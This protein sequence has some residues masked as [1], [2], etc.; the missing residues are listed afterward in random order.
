MV[1]GI[2]GVPTE[3]PFSAQ[4]I[5][6]QK[7]MVV[8]SISH[9]WISMCWMLDFRVFLAFVWKIN[10][11]RPR[12]TCTR[13]LVIVSMV[14][15]FIPHHLEPLA[16]H[17]PF[18]MKKQ[19]IFLLPLSSPTHHF[20]YNN[21]CFLGTLK[22]SEINIQEI[23]LSIIAPFHII[24]PVWQMGKQRTNR[25]GATF[26]FLL[27]CSHTSLFPNCLCYRRHKLQ[28]DYTWRGSLV[29]YLK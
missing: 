25:T 7:R 8:V 12:P 23:I 27:A 26:K 29:S 10:S 9:S 14:W 2:W 18:W 5:P 4:K 6:F 13:R 21:N 17:Q 22:G 15:L 19:R 28:L 16:P 1:A 11:P 24:S 20:L 3:K